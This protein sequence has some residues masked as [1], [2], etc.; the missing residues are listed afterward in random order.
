M[1]PQFTAEPNRT[2]FRQQHT[3]GGRAAT[4]TSSACLEQ[5]AA[6]TEAVGGVVGEWG[7]GV[8]VVQIRRPK[9]S[10]LAAALQ[11]KQIHGLTALEPGA[12]VV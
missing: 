2:L 12:N 11:G 4:L 6:L 3:G 9:R 8:G 10:H 5:R 1:W 7:G